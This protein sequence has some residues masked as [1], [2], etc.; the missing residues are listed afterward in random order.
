MGTKKATSLDLLKK[1]KPV[2]R[3]VTVVVQEDDGETVEVSLVF[4]S[5]GSKAYDDLVAKYPPTEK[6]KKEGLTY[7]IEKF[8]PALVAECCV[9]PEMSLDD[10]KEIFESDSW[11][12]GELMMLFFAAVEVN[13]RGHDLPP[14][15]SD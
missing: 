9:E 2:T 7:N 14:T 10:A 3:E 4:Q 8:A 1:K 6:Q 12:R 5:M 13:T 11:N 15:E